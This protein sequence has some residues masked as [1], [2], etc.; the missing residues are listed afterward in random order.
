MAYLLQRAPR[1]G[2]LRYELPTDRAVWLR[3]E[4]MMDGAPMVAVSAASPSAPAAPTP[5]DSAL[6]VVLPL[7]RQGPIRYA[8]LPWGEPPFRNSDPLPGPEV[9]VLRGGDCLTWRRPEAHR[10]VFFDA[11]QRPRVVP[12]GGEEKPCPVCD[13]PG[14]KGHAAGTCPAL[15]VAHRA[16]AKGC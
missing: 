2:W 13:A 3:L 5:P 1:G 7:R 14:V 4:T 12:H 16:R 11:F 8:V 10:R 9:M 15:W 6:A